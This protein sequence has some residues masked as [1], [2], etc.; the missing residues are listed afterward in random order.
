MRMQI[1]TLVQAIAL[2]LLPVIGNSAIAGLL[3]QPVVTAIGDGTVA[4]S[5][6]GYT[7]SVYLY[8]SNT[9]NQAAPVSSTS[10]NSSAS[11]T[12][13]VNSTSATSEGALS[14]NPGVSDKAALGQSYSGTAYAYSAGY[15]AANNS[16][17]VNSAATN[18]K[19]SLGDVQVTGTSVSGATV[20]QTQTQA[21]AY[22]ANN[23][24]GATGDD[25][26]STLYSAGTGSGTTGGWRNFGSNAIL[27]AAPTNVRTV[28]LLGGSLFGSTG[29]GSTVGIYKIDPT[30]ASA[31]TPF[32]TTGTSSNHSPYEFALFNDTSN[33]SSINGYN[34]AYIAD[35]G[36]AGAAAGGIE[37]WVYNGS[38]WTQSYI[39]RDA[40]LATGVNYRGLAGQLDATTG[41]VTLFAST[42]DGL[43]LQQVTDT[44]AAAAFTTLAAAPTNL[45][46][47]GVALAPVAVPEPGTVVLAGLAAV[48]GLFVA[49]RNRRAS[50]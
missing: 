13:L 44:G 36:A 3:Y 48:C 17:S 45:A 30:G 1:R 41:L 37:K 9:A 29:S 23:I 49:R 46:F 34:V 26:G 20:L 40:Q 27:S 5:G 16:S 39:L 28:E 22:A 8:S 24:R 4:T 38:S 18:A 31:A 42:S 11:G 25:T 6:N 2:T 12:R 7:T 32:I 21:A 14:N 15:D 43:K 50:R 19:R 10:Y 33:Q 47:R 35:D